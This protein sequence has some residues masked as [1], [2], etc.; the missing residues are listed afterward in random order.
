[1]AIVEMDGFKF[2]NGL[3]NEYIVVESDRL[4][5]Y[6]EYIRKNKIKAIYISNLYFFDCNICFLK[7]FEFIEKINITSTS[8]TDFSGLNSLHKLKVLLL[9]DPK[10][11]V[12]LEHNILLEELSVD[13]KNKNILG[14]NKLKKLKI[15]SMCNYNPKSKD[16]SDI[17]TLDS[18][19]EL[20]IV[21][22]TIN[23]FKGC[24]E[25]TNLKKLSFSYLNKLEYIDDLVANKQTLKVLEFDSCK[26]IKNYDY[27]VCLSNLEKLSYNECGEMESIEFINK[28][29]NLKSFIFIKTNV[30]N[31]D[32][33][34]CKRLEYV[35]FDNK[36][37]YSHKMSD[38][39]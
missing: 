25:L 16:L 35:A 13:M 27:V 39:N 2:L 31:G 3:S 4:G 10:G 30:I 29:P 15:L 14:F 20:D 9:D 26:K 36:R 37:H 17:S 33:S 8:V 19:E 21:K 6:I 7:E 28:M 24:G 34:P 23:S 11:K 38:F 12:N 1:M 5:K 22:S 18:I 32:L